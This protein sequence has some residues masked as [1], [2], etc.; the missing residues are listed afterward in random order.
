MKR[1]RFLTVILAVGLLMVWGCGGPKNVNTQNVKC[2]AKI[3]W[4]VVPEA[5]VTSFECMQTTYK[6]KPAIAF[7]MGLKNVSDKPMRYKVHIFLV[8][9]NKAVG[10]KVP[11][12]GK[13]NKKTGKKG[14]PLLQPGQTVKVKYPVAKTTTLP[15]KL[16]VVVETCPAL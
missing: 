9:E 11:R 13:K 1:V 3:S 10:G 2:P 7:V 6:K 5:Q 4:Q 15:A 16:E 14:K 12:K 8:E